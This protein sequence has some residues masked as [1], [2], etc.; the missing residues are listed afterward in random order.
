MCHG[1]E[2]QQVLTTTSIVKSMSHAKVLPKK[3]M[4]KRHGSLQ[5]LC[6]KLSERPK[7]GHR[8][9]HFAVGIYTHTYQRC[10]KNIY[11]AEHG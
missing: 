1:I 4:R 3:P 5:M 7:I 9:R 2:Y 11:N 8:A 10:G 6:Y